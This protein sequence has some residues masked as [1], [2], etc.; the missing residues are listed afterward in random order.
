MGKMSSCY[1]PHS[2]PDWGVITAPSKVGKY[3]GPFVIVISSMNAR[4]GGC[5]T[6]DDINGPRLIFSTDF[7][8]K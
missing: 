3:N 2:N 7:I 8:Y 4:V 5:L 1:D 6:P